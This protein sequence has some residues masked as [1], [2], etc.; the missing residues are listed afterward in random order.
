MVAIN[1]TSSNRTEFAYDGFSRR[2]RITEKVNSSKSLL[3]AGQQIVEER[4]S[5]GA[6]V[7]KRFFPQGEQIAGVPYYFTRDHLGSIRELTDSTGTN[8]VARYDYDPYGRRTLVSGTDLADFGFTGHYFHAPSRLNL[9]LYRVYDANLGRWISKDPLGEDA[10]LNLYDYCFGNPVNLLDKDGKIPDKWV[11]RYG[12]WGG[13]DWSGGWRPSENG[14]KDGP[15]DP[16]DSMD[17]LFKQHDLD[18]EKAGV[19]PSTPNK[20][21]DKIKDSCEKKKC[22]DKAAA[23]RKLRDGLKALDYS[24]AEWEKPA[25]NTRAALYYRQWTLENFPWPD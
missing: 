1:E 12:N 5:T 11:P 18:Y 8:I 15:S 24:P 9:T 3:W 10:G 14:G 25:P 17:E 23:D 22:K 16:I 13:P 19:T 7:T 20:N 6:N 4:D 2:V 21:C